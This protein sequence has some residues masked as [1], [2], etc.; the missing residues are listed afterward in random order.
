MACSSIKSST[1]YSPEQKQSKSTLTLAQLLDNSGVDVL[2]VISSTSS[3]KYA[4]KSYKLYSQFSGAEGLSVDEYPA[5]LRLNDF[6]AINENQYKLGDKLISIT[7]GPNSVAE[8]WFGRTNTC[9]WTSNSF[10]YEC[11]WYCPGEIDVRPANNFYEID[12]ENPDV[13][14]KWT[15]DIRNDS[16]L[17]NIAWHEGVAISGEP[18]ATGKTTIAIPDN[19]L[20]KVDRELLKDFYSARDAAQE[21][22]ALLKKNGSNQ[23]TIIPNGPLHLRFQRANYEFAEHDGKTI[24]NVCYSW[25]ELELY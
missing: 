16:V 20:V 21:R 24:K 25:S 23:R 22:R 17:V 5:K 2:T 8:K 14:L 15:A 11:D 19:G 12:I 4:N 9:K 18:R 13:L 3:R 10:N 1:I 7:F 6:D